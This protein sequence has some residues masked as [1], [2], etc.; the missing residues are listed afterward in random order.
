MYIG[1]ALV[2]LCVLI[3]GT[4]A[5]H[6]SGIAPVSCGEESTVRRKCSF[7]VVRALLSRMDADI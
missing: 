3:I 1:L 4:A 7:T 5:V 2:I 6:V